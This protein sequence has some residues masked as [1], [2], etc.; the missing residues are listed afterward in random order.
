MVV[1]VWGRFTD[2]MCI[3]PAKVWW[4]KCEIVPRRTAKGSLRQSSFARQVPV[5]T[6]AYGS[7]RDHWH[8]DS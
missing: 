1:D 7:L 5:A 2:A 8:Q 4:C 3:G 6:A